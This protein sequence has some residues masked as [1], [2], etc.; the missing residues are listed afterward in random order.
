M[1][2]AVPP[3][4]IALPG[5]SGLGTA[6]IKLGQGLVFRHVEQHRHHDI[7][8]QVQRAT[9]GHAQAARQRP[10][11]VGPDQQPHA[12]QRRAEEQGQ[13]QPVEHHLVDRLHG[14]HRTL[15]GDALQGFHHE[16]GEGEE[17]PAHQATAQ[18]GGKYQQ[19]QQDFD[20]AHGPVL[21]QRGDRH[22]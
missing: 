18:G 2:P 21:R 19:Q 1:V 5:R 4:H 16:V 17:Q 10:A 13:E 20:K 9:N 7:A 3:R 12:G 15:F 6:R 8:R 11:L 22:G 14:R